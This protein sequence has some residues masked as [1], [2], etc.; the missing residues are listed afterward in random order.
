MTKLQSTLTLTVLLSA[1]LAASIVALGW[2]EFAH[3]WPVIVPE[4]WRDVLDTVCRCVSGA[5]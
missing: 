1:V 2:L 5:G 3:N 4:H